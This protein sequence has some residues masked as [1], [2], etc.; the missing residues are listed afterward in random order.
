[1][2]YEGT[3][4]VLNFSKLSNINK[5]PS[6]HLRTACNQIKCTFNYTDYIVWTRSDKTRKINKHVYFIQ[7][8]IY[9]CSVLFR[10]TGVENFSHRQEF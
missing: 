10:I 5:L 4:T 6:L 1:M 8:Q 7:G 3:S 2:Y 9:S